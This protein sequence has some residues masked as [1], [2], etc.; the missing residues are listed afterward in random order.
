MRNRCLLLTLLTGAAIYW[1]PG[2]GAC[3][4]FSNVDL[5]PPR[6]IIGATVDFV[7][8]RWTIRS[9]VVSVP[10]RRTMAPIAAICSGETRQETPWLLGNS[11]QMYRQYPLTIYK[12]QQTKKP[13]ASMPI[14]VLSS[15]TWFLCVSIDRQ[16]NL[17]R[18]WFFVVQI[19][20][21]HV[22]LQWC[23]KQEERNEETSGLTLLR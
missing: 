11:H 5:V 8:P 16:C 12:I 1:W 4:I 6:W 14:S 2:A 19:C 18:P 20:F 15:N 13:L 23:L 10:P 3:T 22:R 9:N 7:P 17:R 21:L